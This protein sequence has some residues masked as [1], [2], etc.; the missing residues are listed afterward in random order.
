MS[1]ITPE[2]AGFSLTE[3]DEG[4]KSMIEQ[5]ED[6]LTQISPETP[7]KR[8]VPGLGAGQII[9]HPSFYDPMTEEELQDWGY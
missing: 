6:V 2:Q 3:D 9:I 8:R 7:K 5:E 4:E 1:R